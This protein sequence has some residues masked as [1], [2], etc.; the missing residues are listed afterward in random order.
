MDAN[1]Y[2]MNHPA[3]NS[4]LDERD[5]QEPLVPVV[6][7]IRRLAK[8]ETWQLFGDLVYDSLRG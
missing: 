5:S 6:V 4:T 3:H 8:L 7:E 2:F 1:L